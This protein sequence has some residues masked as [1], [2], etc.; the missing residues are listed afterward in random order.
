MLQVVRRL[1]MTPL[2]PLVLLSNYEEFI[3]TV[4]I[5]S[6]R[7]GNFV[8]SYLILNSLFLSVSFLFV[9]FVSFRFFFILFVVLF[10]WFFIFFV[11]CFVCL[12]CFIMYERTVALEANN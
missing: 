5:N 12:F 3:I 9:R 6:I 2:I 1:L 8:G 11:V 7:S 10:F 4:F